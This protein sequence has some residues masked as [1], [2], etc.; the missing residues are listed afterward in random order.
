V[1]TGT[2]VGWIGLLYAMTCLA[3]YYQDQPS[4]LLPDPKIVSQTHRTKV[5]QSLVLCKYTE[6]PPFAIEGLLILLQAEYL[7]GNDIDLE[8][9]TS[10]ILGV[11]V[12]LA[13]RRGYH[14]DASHFPQISKLQGEMQRRIWTEIIK[15]DTLASIQTG[16]PRLIRRSHYD[17]NEPSNLSDGDLSR[18]DGIISEGRHDSALTPIQY[19]IAY[20]RILAIYCNITDLVSGL[21]PPPYDKIMTMDMSLHNTYASI[22]VR[23]RMPPPRDGLEDAGIIDVRQ[24]LI[25]LIFKEAQCVLHQRYLHLAQVDEYSYSRSTCI[26]AALDILRYQEHLEMQTHDTKSVL[27]SRWRLSPFAKSSFLLATSV[28]CF[29]LGGASSAAL[30]TPSEGGGTKTNESQ[31]VVEAL[32]KCHRIW[33]QRVSC[34]FSASSARMAMAINVVLR[35]AGRLS[36]QDPDTEA[37]PGMCIPEITIWVLK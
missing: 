30:T 23:L 12:K 20:N 21:T 3:S 16:L 35:K 15:L 32:E 36:T 26:S 34:T 7:R 11:V 13:M 2:Q 5:I 8:M 19:N 25:A 1:G 10:L 29:E 9:S 14:R 27:Q 33:T 28:L 18:E 22:P 6:S 4:S 17:T 31:Q 37:G 24:I